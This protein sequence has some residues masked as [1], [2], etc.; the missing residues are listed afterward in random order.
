MQSSVAA[1]IIASRSFETRVMQ[2]VWPQVASRNLQPTVVYCEPTPNQAL[3]LDLD[4]QEEVGRLTLWSDGS[5][6][7]EALKTSDGSTIHSMNG[8]VASESDLHGVLESLINSFS[9]VEKGSEHLWRFA[10]RMAIKTAIKSP[11]WFALAALA[12][13]F[14]PAWSPWPWYIATGFVAIGFAVALFAWVG[15]Q[16]AFR[17]ERRAATETFDV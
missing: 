4:G 10:R 8:W 6:A 11:V 12:V 14:F 3:R 2:A 13:Y 1:Y 5:Y 7:A 16:F 9:Q 17:A 15:F